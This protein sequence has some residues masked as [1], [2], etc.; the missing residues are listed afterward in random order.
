M[1]ASQTT[2]AYA[3]HHIAGQN[4]TVIRRILQEIGRPVVFLTTKHVRSRPAPRR[5][6]ITLNTVVCTGVKIA[7]H[8]A[9]F[10]THGSSQSLVVMYRCKQKECPR[11]VDGTITL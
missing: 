1:T 8:Q 6:P 9:L 11:F 2:P 5:H 3:G 10:I 4:A 7:V